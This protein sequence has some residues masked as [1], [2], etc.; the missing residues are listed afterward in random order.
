[1]VGESAMQTLE[2]P[3][4]SSSVYNKVKQAIISGELAAGSRITEKMLENSLD[5]SRGPVR[6]AI[7]RLVHEGYLKGKSY[8]GYRV[9]HPT[10][11][12]VHD[13]MEVVAALVG[14]AFELC[15]ERADDQQVATLSAEV[16][17]MEREM[18]R[19]LREG[20]F[21][22]YG[23]KMR[24]FM[25]LPVLFSRNEVLVSL[26]ERLTNHPAY[27]LPWGIDD[28]VAVLRRA[29]DFPLLRQAV[30]ERD[31]VTGG[32]VICDMLRRSLKDVLAELGEGGGGYG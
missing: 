16:D 22:L 25:R 3:T 9:N 7:V 4:L 19:G 18:E 20:G 6:E 2:R 27:I 23:A 28:P 1:M 17:A 15:M 8:K 10:P 30:L 5:V 12:E 32:R 13:T 24:Q 29:P 14:A 26:Y 11:R 31:G 21:E